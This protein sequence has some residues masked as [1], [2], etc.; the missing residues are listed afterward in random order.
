MNYKRGTKID[1]SSAIAQALLDKGLSPEGADW[2]TLRLDPYHDFIRPIAGYPDADC[3]DTLVSCR[4]YEYN[5]SKPP[6]LGAGNWDAHVF[7]LP[8]D[9]LTLHNGNIVNGQFTQ[10]A[11]NF[12]VGLVNV[13]KDATGGPLFPTA[14][15]VASANFSMVSIDSFQ[16]IEDGISRIIGMG[17]EIIET[18]SVLN[19]QGALTAYKMP[20]VQSSRT[21]LGL[22]NTAGTQ[23]SNLDYEYFQAPPSTLAEAVLFRSTVQWEAKEGAYMV[24]GQNGVNNPFVSPGRNN[25]CVSK[26]FTVTG[27]DQALCTFPTAVTAL[28]VPPLVTSAYSSSVCKIQNIP[29][30][31]I[32]LTGLANDATFKVRVRVYIE[33]APMRGDSDLIPLATPSAGY[34][35]RAL[36]IYSRL[37]STLPVAVPV[38]FNAKG[39][40]WKMILG[41]IRKVAPLAGLLLSPALGPAAST[42]GGAVGEIAGALAPSKVGGMQKGANQSFPPP[43]PLPPIPKEK[44]KNGK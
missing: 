5:V 26:D 35:I 44:K 42:I 15:P 38:G 24:V 2:L 27:T 28:Q 34:D 6:G 30:Q 12:V 10:T 3:F 20:T 29:Q 39:D 13:A 36:E 14:V 16:A 40:W 1:R 11:E 25:I 32:F 19:K 33:R 21:N 31:G 41:I 17:I 22:L 8:F 18:S 4:N 9:G 23:Q 7:T 43:K 37:V